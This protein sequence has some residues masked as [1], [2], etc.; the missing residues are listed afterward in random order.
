M[1]S[2]I[3]AR[4]HFLGAALGAVATAGCNGEVSWGD[5]I[6]PPVTDRVKRALD[7][8]DGQVRAQMRRTGVPGVA[9]AVVHEGRLVYAQ[10][11]GVRRL[12]SSLAVDADTVFQ[13]ASVSKSVGA[14]VVAQQVGQRRVSWD[15]R[16][17][18]GLPWWTLEDADAAQR[19]TVGDMYA[20]RS[21]LPGQAGDAL[22]ELGYSQ[23]QILER[24]RYL[25]LRPVGTQYAYSNFGLTTGAEA[26][27][28]IAGQ[29]WAALS[30]Q[31][32][33]GPLGMTQTSSLFADFEAR[34]NRAAGHLRVNGVWQAGPVRRP[35]A[36]SA[37]GG[38]SSTVRDMARWMTMLLDEGRFE[39]RQVVDAQALR[40]ALSPQMLQSPAGNGEPAR[41]YG[42]GFNVGV[43]EAGRTTYS[44]SGA[45]GTGSATSFTVM[46]ELK[47]G[48]VVLT[49]G[50]PIGVPEI[51]VSQF[52]DQVEWGR[53]RQDWES[54]WTKRL[55]P[56]MQPHGELVGK[57]RPSFPRP[58]RPLGA[59]VGSYA[60]RFYG[61]AQVSLQTGG[62][63]L[64]VSLGSQRMLL[65]HWDG[66]VFSFV[67]EGD[68]PGSLSKA[69]FDGN[70]LTLEYFDDVL[71]PAGVSAGIGRFSR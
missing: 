66:E 12:G 17:Q 60:N 32:V 68:S 33:Y 63:G 23:R 45:F 71:T 67:P 30:Q 28:A 53:Q 6:D 43:S 14:T 9:V 15:T 2:S 51:V 48:I 36:Q 47:L 59:Y 10:G 22:E 41:Y 11:M 46:P 57:T 8:L 65:S 69:T 18:Q 7:Q 70:Q 16:V 54:I 49:N 62:G 3:L 52:L 20:H 40:T 44:H 50:M 56:I 58:P 34:A 39:G 38:V 26:V 64:Q 25:P 24:L 55:A 4:R 13:L 1:A 19:I 27:A 37:A 29:S 5:P 35:D 21:G 61:P 31:A 42:F